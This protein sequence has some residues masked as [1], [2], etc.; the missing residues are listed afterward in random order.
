MT[1][2]RCLAALALVTAAPLAGHAQARPTE[3]LLPL[4]SRNDAV[5]VSV[6]RVSE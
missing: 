3:E 6:L 2:L 5:D 1:K 4:V